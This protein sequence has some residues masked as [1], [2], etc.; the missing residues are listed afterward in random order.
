MPWQGKAA[1]W[2]LQRLRLRLD[3]VDFERLLNDLEHVL[4]HD[5]DVSG[6]L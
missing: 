5:R 1:L 2:Y 4:L 6:Q 3:A